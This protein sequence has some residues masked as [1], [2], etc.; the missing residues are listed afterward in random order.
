MNRTNGDLC[1]DHSGKT[2]KRTGNTK[3]GPNATDIKGSNERKTKLIEKSLEYGAEIVCIVS[4]KDKTKHDINSNYYTTR[5]DRCKFIC[6]CKKECE[7]DIRSII[8]KTGMLC[9]TCK[10]KIKQQKR[11]KTNKK[12]YG[13]EEQIQIES[14]KNKIKETNKKRYGNENHMQIASIKN[15]MKETRNTNKKIKSNKTYY[16]AVKEFESKLKEEMSAFKIQRMYKKVKSKLYIGRIILLTRAFYMHLKDPT[17]YLSYK[18]AI[19][20]LKSFR[21]SSTNQYQEFVGHYDKIPLHKYPKKREYPEFSWTTYL[22]NID[23]KNRKKFKHIIK[24]YKE[25][26]EF[27]KNVVWPWVVK[28]GHHHLS[29]E[30]LWNKYVEVNNSKSKNNRGINGYPIVPRHHYGRDA[31]NEEWKKNG[32]WEGFFG[33]P[34]KK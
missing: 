21:F 10:N 29:W 8:Q 9:K 3:K 6:K 1:K 26:S 18:S 20:F 27:A 34:E 33:N 15:K 2:W 13:N 11:K 28:N 23:F 22:S 24:T 19:T 14:I 17:E 4:K 31:K 12:K 16:K 5:V 30:N 7:S 25:A 32:N